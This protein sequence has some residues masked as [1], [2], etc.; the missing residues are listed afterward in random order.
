MPPPVL[1]EVN[2]HDYTEEHPCFNNRAHFRFGRIHLPVAPRCNLQCAYC[3]RRFDCPN[4][5]RPGVTSKLISPCEAVERVEKALKKD[6]RLR[7]IGIAGPGEPLYNDETY[8]VM[9]LLYTRFPQLSLCVST[10]GLLLPERLKDLIICGLRTLTITINTVRLATARKIYS[11]IVY[12]RQS[13]LMD[14]GCARLLRQ[15]RLGL[16]LAVESG[17][18]VKVNTVLIP[19]INE[20]EIEEIS[21]MAADEGAYIMNIMPLIPQ[22]EFANIPPPT[23]ML[24]K[25]CRMGAGNH[26]PQFMHCKQC[27]ADAVGVP[28]ES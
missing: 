22:A 28:G 5:A 11:S 23:A 25:T 24:L 15:Q 16:R 20:T 6:N 8:E 17:L 3:N 12:N 1:S 13:L 18:A 9:R 21:K 26:L 27:R 19:G 7:V 2:R 10:N 4:E 14:E